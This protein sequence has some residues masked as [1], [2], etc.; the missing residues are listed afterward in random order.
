MLRKETFHCDAELNTFFEQ[1]REIYI[2]KFIVFI[3]PMLQAKEYHLIY[4]VDTRMKG[5]MHLRKGVQNREEMG[6]QNKNQIG[7]RA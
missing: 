7:R 5:G 3:N 6:S 1:C 2:V 4:S